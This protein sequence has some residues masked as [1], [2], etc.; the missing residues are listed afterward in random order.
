M[1][2]YYH[3]RQSNNETD[4]TTGSHGIYPS[5]CEG[6][7]I[8][9][10]IVYGNHGNGIKP[11]FAGDSATPVVDKNF[12]ITGNVCVENGLNG[13][14]NGI[15]LQGHSQR[16]V[17]FGNVCYNNANNGIRLQIENKMAGARAHDNLVAGNVAILHTG[18]PG[19]DAPISIEDPNNWLVYN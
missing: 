7:I 17:L 9:E 2:E 10:N 13:E 18:D 11:R 1:Q 5:G 4:P 8:S 6:L 15:N 14:G 12:C 3:S 16:M 19:D